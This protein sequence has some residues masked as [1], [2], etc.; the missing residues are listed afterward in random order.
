MDALQEKPTV[1]PYDIGI[2]LKENSQ[3]CIS[4]KYKTDLTKTDQPVIDF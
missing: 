2:K 3:S 4:T 1:N